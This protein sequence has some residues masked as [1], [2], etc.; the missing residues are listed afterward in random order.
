MKKLPLL[1]LLPVLA[2]AQSERWDTYMARLGS[3]PASV[4]VDMDA[5]RSAPDK[6]M[7]YLVVTGPKAAKC[8]GK[9]GIP[10]TGDIARMERILD[11]TTAFM[12]GVT[13]KKLV[14]TLTY[15]CERLNYYY[16]K[17]TTAVRNALIR[18]YANNYPSWE[19]TLKI[20]PE[21][22]W[23]T[24]RTFLY[25][26]SAA[27]SWMGNNR[28]MTAMLEAGDDL[29]SPRPI[30]H[31]VYFKTD[32]GRSSFLKYATL[33]GFA[34]HTRHDAPTTALPYELVVQHTGRVIM[35]SV[36]AQQAILSVAS[37]QYEG[38]YKGWEAPLR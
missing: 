30:L 7:P 2:H 9:T 16:V 22:Q 37:K 26:D 15:N 36:M 6:L 38:Y 10:D 28:Q 32:S 8:P 13:A 17:D 11:L 35:D 20:K 4:L 33:Q 1:L 18:L 25:P 34:M 31:T 12:S 19:Y 27:L 5:A 14:G 29:L 21:P 23:A 24:Y 3:K